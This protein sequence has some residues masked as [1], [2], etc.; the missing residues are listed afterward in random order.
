MLHE[1]GTGM[2]AATQPLTSTAAPGGM[3]GLTLGLN[4][5]PSILELC[6]TGALFLTSSDWPSRRATM[7]GSNMQQGWSSDTTFCLTALRAGWTGISAFGFLA[8]TR[9]ATTQRTPL[10]LGLTTSFWDRSG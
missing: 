3:I 7:C 2:A 10:F 1:T 9:Y 6:A 5:P 4:V 8:S